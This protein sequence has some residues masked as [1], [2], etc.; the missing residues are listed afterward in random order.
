MQLYRPVHVE[1]TEEVPDTLMRITRP[2]TTRC[3]APPETIASWLL[4]EW[5]DPSKSA[6]FVESRNETGEGDEPVTVGF[7]DDEL[8][9]SDFITWDDRRQA[10]AIPEQTAR[11]AL[12]YF[13]IFYDIHSAMEKDAEEL[14]L[15]VADG[16][17]SWQ[18]TSGI[19]GQITID[20]P[21][22][23]KRV[24]LRFDAAVPEFTIHETDRE[25]E[26]YGGLFLDLKD[27]APVAI[28]KRKDELEGSGYHPLGWQ[29]TD[30]FLKAFIQTVSPADGEF[31]DSPAEGEPS[32][33]PRLWRAPV[34]LL[35]K[36]VAGIANA[37]D[38]IIDDIDHQQVFPSAL[39]EITGEQK[40]WPGNGMGGGSVESDASSE[41]SVTQAIGDDDILLALETNA[42]Q[43]E[44]IRRLQR[45][46]SVIV[47]GP[48]GTGKTH[49]IANLVGHLLAQGK[50][51]LV[52]AQTAKALRVLR[53][54]V[55]EVL[56]PLCVSVLGSDRDAR[57][58]LESSIGSITERLTSDSSATLLD[59]A[60]TFEGERRKLLHRIKELG[61]KLRKALE[62]EYRD[63][64]VGEQRFTP[65]DA[66]RFVA[67]HREEQA[68]IPGPVKLGAKISLSDQ[69]L[70]RIYALGRSY[71]DEEE[72]DT[73]H[74]LPELA[75]LPPEREF[76]MMASEHN[77]L[78]T[79]D[80]SLGADRWQGGSDSTAIESLANAIDSEFSDELR[81]QPWRPRAIVAGIH[82]G[83]D[84]QV[85]ESLITN[86][87]RAAQA[88]SQH[89]L[90]MH[91]RPSL[92][93][94]LPIRR[95][96]H[97]AIE[98][99][100][101]LAGGGNVGLIQLAIR[102]EWRQFIK[103][104]SVTAGRPTH[105]DHFEAI[106]CLAELEC[107]RLELASRWNSLIGTH[108]EKPF[109][110]LGDS[111]ELSARALIPEIRRCLDWHASVWLPLTERLKAEGLDL[112]RVLASFPHEASAIAEFI[113]IERLATDVL[114]SLLVSEAGR[115][116]VKECEAWFD[117]LTEMSV[118]VDPT[119]PDRGCIGRILAA[120]QSRNVDA[121]QVAVDYTRRLHTIKPLVIERDE[122]L[123]K[124][125]LVA[126]GWSE[127]IA[128][129]V[130]PHNDGHI[131]GDVGL[132]WTWRQV[133]DELAE[134]DRLD[135]H[136]LQR[137][138]D[139]ARS[140]LRQ[141]TE[142]LIDSKAWGKQLERLQSDHSVRQAL[143]GWLDTTKRSSAPA[144]FK[145][146]KP[147]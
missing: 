86:I 95:Q 45:S 62:N 23:F 36:R 53:D 72:H 60:T 109:D 102:S 18:T 43:L 70:V 26:L 146:D 63:I 20:H 93:A 67:R 66:A 138:I 64:A 51:I 28:R 82:G 141:V 88:Y 37:V 1:N 8:R 9:V 123:A 145:G 15:L 59:K 115:R 65:S 110:A 126:P 69:E 35:R 139:D 140:T 84:R 83:T 49:T 120:V 7:D 111:P 106:G 97:L 124:L 80:L 142:L 56:Q 52:T 117:R 89:A 55:P 4:P 33:S 76:Q 79:C 40:K 50:S 34:L 112:D 100:D 73:R 48:P 2:E 92:G 118:Q 44:L 91:H 24:E 143:V 99:C 21:I 61:R 104:V 94:T 127:H 68:W 113:F 135:A 22:L 121:Y 25:P 125:Q 10:W 122:L 31:L 108:I 78:L 57:R 87:E 19:D 131:P 6:F 147:C 54:K 3:P 47:Q 134:R 58:Q 46:G 90:V 119:A 98:I 129:R 137:Q 41:P 132:A 16:H 101:H 136:Q 128:R 39:A 74:P 38:R 71:T 11:T 116:K 29:D 42:E 144:R 12:R 85:W 5:D 130:K 107:L 27:V 96:W 13:E 103:T 81:R 17:M 133:H 32:I 30:A 114:P 14:E 75:N 77:H 105:K